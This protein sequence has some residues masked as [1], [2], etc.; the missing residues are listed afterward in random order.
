[1][2]NQD[3]RKIMQND[4]LL[5]GKTKRNNRIWGFGG[6]LCSDKHSIHDMFFGSRP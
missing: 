2:A 4:T 5:I 1:M 3:Y 6:T